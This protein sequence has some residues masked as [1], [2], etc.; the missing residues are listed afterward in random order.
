M[1]IEKKPDLD[2]NRPG[3]MEAMARQRKREEKLRPLR[4]NATTTILVPRGKCNKKY[5]EQYRNRIAKG[6]V[7]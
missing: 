6:F 5:A 2:K 3:V 7:I 4:I 1:L